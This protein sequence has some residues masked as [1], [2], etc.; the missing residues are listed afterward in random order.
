VGL[1]AG[2]RDGPALLFCLWEDLNLSRRAL[3]VNTIVIE[4]KKGQLGI[5]PSGQFSPEWSQR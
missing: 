2:W 3:K 5:N 1:S 4:F